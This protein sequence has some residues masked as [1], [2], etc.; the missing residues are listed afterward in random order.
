MEAKVRLDDSHKIGEKYSAIYI[1][2]ADAV[3]AVD[4]QE[5]EIVEEGAQITIRVKKPDLTFYIDEAE[6]EKLAEWQKNFFSGSTEDGYKA[7]MNSRIEMEKKSAEEIA[8]YDTLMDMAQE[9]AKSRSSFLWKQ[10]AAGKPES[11]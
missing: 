2:K 4:L 6:T 10:S 9:S 8:N 5:A 3:F 11:R 1:Y 7:Y